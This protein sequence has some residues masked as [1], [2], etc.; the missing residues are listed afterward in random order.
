MSLSKCDLR[1]PIGKFCMVQVEVRENGMFFRNGCPD[2]VKNNYLEIGDFLVFEYD[3][4]STFN[5]NVYGRNACEKDIRVAKKNNDNPISLEKKGK[6][7][8]KKESFG[9]KAIKSIHISFNGINCELNYILLC[10]FCLP[11]FVIYI[12]IYIYIYI[13]S[14]LYLCAISGV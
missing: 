2:F 8:Q 12:Y 11:V 3:G 13:I 1:S 10:C 9:K 4:K 7:V 14:Y 6:Q 5:V